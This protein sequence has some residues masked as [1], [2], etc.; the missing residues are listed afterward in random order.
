MSSKNKKI[1]SLGEEIANS[2]SHGVGAGLSI[3]A[4]VVLIIR[5]CFTSD[6][7]G[8]VGAALYG[9]SLIILYCASTLYHSLTNP[10]A[11]GVFRIFDHCSIF[12][13]IL[14]TYIPICF[15]ALR[16]AMGW[17]LFGINAGCTV[18]GVV[19]NSIDLEKWSKLSLVLYLFMGWSFVMAIKPVM[20]AFELKQLVFLIIGGLCY[21]V[22]IIFYKL[23]NIKYFHYIWHLFVLAGS[24][25]QFFFVFFEC[26]S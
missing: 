20:Y 26:Y 25:F 23:S 13:L 12:I 18:L 17:T 5:A 7:L 4:T 11:K 1:Q 14:G 24:V 10:T 15:T 8:I 19:F 3:A 16:G 9:A 2:V 21:T 22:G 6:A